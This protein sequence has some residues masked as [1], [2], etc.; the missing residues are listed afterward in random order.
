MRFGNKELYASE[1]VLIPRKGSLNNIMY[2][3]EPFWTVDTMFFTENGYKNDLFYV[4]GVT[5]L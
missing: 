5:F 2:I 4:L 1:S 3:D